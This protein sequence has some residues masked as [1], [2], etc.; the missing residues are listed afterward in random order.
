[1]PKPS[2]PILYIC[3]TCKRAGSQ[4]APQGKPPEGRKLYE[5]VAERMENLNGE[6]PAELR[7]CVCFGNCEQGCTVA[8]SEPGKWSYIMGRLGHEN[9]DDLIAYAGA[10]AKSGT[11]TVFR[12]GRPAALHDTI[13]ARMPGH[14]QRFKESV[15]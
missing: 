4:A 12:S 7:S 14:L 11:G 15:E 3:L 13:I 9:A 1:M 5:A 10:Y 8:I 2:R 6:A